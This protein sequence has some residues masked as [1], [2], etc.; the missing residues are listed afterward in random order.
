MNK[1]MLPSG[2]LIDH[3]CSQ[4]GQIALLKGTMTALGFANQTTTTKRIQQSRH[5]KKRQI[6]VAVSLLVLLASIF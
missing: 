1:Y 4:T 3:V 5:K 6:Q 2:N